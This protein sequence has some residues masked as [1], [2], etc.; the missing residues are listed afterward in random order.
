MKNY[1]VP[2]DAVAADCHRKSR[3]GVQRRIILDLRTL[4]EFNPLIVAAQN[5]AEPDTRLG[6]EPNAADQYRG[7]RDIVLAGP[8]KFRRLSFKLVNSHIVATPWTPCAGMTCLNRIGVES[9]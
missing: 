4:P 3:I 6:L 1:V 8:G 7:V 5:C 9:G 2:D